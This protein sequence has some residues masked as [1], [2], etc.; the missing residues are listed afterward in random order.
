MI[1]KNFA[2]DKKFSAN[3]NLKL[4]TNPEKILVSGYA[5]K[6][7]GYDA[8]QERNDPTKVI[9]FISVNLS[10]LFSELAP[11]TFDYLEITRI[12]VL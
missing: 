6:D 2:N 10:I 5:W 11:E 3:I 4:I 12:E 8:R 1:T 9:E 7:N